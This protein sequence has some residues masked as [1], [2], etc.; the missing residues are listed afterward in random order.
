MILSSD[1][2]VKLQKPSCSHTP[3][4]AAHSA[5]CSPCSHLLKIH[6]LKFLVMSVRGDFLVRLVFPSLKVQ[7]MRLGIGAKFPQSSLIFR[8]ALEVVRVVRGGVG[9][10]VIVA[11][12]SRLSSF[13][14]PTVVTAQQI[15]GC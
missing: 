4:Y 5:L 14:T 7:F 10:L 3:S 8:G 11:F 2:C 9:N 12:V 13:S 1:S 6:F 15:K